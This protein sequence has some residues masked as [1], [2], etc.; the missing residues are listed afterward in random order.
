GTPSQPI[1]FTGTTAQPGWW[2]DIYIQGTGEAPNLNSVLHYVTVQYGGYYDA[3]VLVENGRVDIS[4]SILRNSGHDGLRTRRGG[5][6]SVIESNQIVGNADYGV[7]NTDTTATLNASNNWWGSASGPRT[8]N[9]CNTGGT[10][11]RVSIGVVFKPFL[12]DANQEPGALAPRDIRILSITPQ[13][14]FVPADGVSRAYITL[15]LLDGNGNPMPGRTVRLHSTLGTVTDGGV[16]NV[17]GQTLAYLVAS[18]AGDAQLTA[19]VDN[20]ATC[21]TVQP[22]AP[23]TITF[24]PYSAAANLLPN[25]AAPY[26]SKD[27]QIDPEPIARGVPTTLRVTLTNPN[28]FPI[29]VNGTF[30]WLQTG[31]GLNFNP[32]PAVNNIEIAANGSRTIAVLWTPAISGHYCVQFQY[33]WQPASAAV[34]AAGVTGG[35]G[36]AQRNLDIKPAAFLGPGPKNAASRARAAGSAI[37]DGNTAVG[38][39]T[40]PEGGVVGFIQGQMVGNILGFI[41]DVGGGIN[42]ALAGGAN[43]KGWSGPSLQLPGGSA[44][45]LKDPPRQDYS[46]LATLDTIAFPAVQPGPDMPAARATALNNLTS[47]S[48]DLMVKLVAASVSYDRYGGAVAASDLTWSA[49]QANAYIYYVQEAGKAMLTVADRWDQLAQE[50]RGEGFTDVLVRTSDYAA[51]QTRLQSQGFAADELQ[52]AHIAGLTDEGIENTLQFRIADD[53]NRTAGN[54][55]AKWAMLAASLR[56]LGGQLSTL[57]AISNPTVEITGGTA[58]NR[59][60][61]AENTSTRL[62]R[63]YSTSFDFQVGNPQTNPAQVTLKVRRLDM[64]SDWIV[65]VT[66]MTA[67]LAVG[68][69]ITATVTVNPGSSVAQGIQPQVAVEGYIGGQLIGGVVEQISVPRYALFDGKL[70]IYLPATEK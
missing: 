53:P 23:A 39:L 57:Q 28:N 7:R 36:F 8:D 42:C 41:Y 11:D 1:T 5:Y 26:M 49:L 40:S 63:V 59:S 31:I 37:D 9:S 61:S 58:A 52:A 30:G 50:L 56:D 16:T 29:S 65:T 45:L 27:I 67:T 70:R 17:Q 34:G 19:S 18:S 35:N 20:A 15:T 66:P 51:Y 62:A 68:Q 48:I 60:T 44:S 14:W 43:C 3:N 55:M 46:L 10:G 33:A 22:P 25:S 2:D 4:H 69:Q 38:L 32:L 54:Q 47:D 24:T 21:E 6:T 12:T 13:A 64:P